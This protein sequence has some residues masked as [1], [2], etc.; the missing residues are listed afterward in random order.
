MFRLFAIL[1]IFVV[2]GIGIGETISRVRQVCESLE[3]DS[4]LA[5]PR[6]IFWLDESTVIQWAPSGTVQCQDV[7]SGKILWKRQSFFNVTDWSLSRAS[8]R[9]AIRHQGEKPDES[10][11]DS[12]ICVLDC[13]SGKTIFAKSESSPFGNENGEGIADLLDLDF[14]YVGCLAL[15][16]KLGKLVLCVS[17]NTY[18]KHGYILSRDFR[19]IEDR[20]SVDAGAESL[21]ISP[22]GHRSTIVGHDQVLC[23]HDLE[24]DKELLLRGDRQLV[25]PEKSVYV[26][27]PPY[28]SRASHDGKSCLVSR[29]NGGCW[30]EGWIVV[31][32]ISANTK[33]EFSPDG[34]YFVMDVDFNNKR[35]AVTG[36]SRDLTII[37]FDCNVV[38]KL[39][40]ATSKKVLCV[41]L[42]PSGDQVVT[43]SSDNKVTVFSITE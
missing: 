19:K 20:F 11:G 39:D 1:L 30:S 23:I 41:K 38:A 43:V 14:A 22:Q 12:T 2:P 35:I 9:L 15:T 27:G 40:H 37:D 7:Q 28:L 4:K 34:N 33:S 42:S 5:G 17:E 29:F 24:Q 21:S 6:H 3:D 26:T 10:F 16:P 32:D 8:S 31:E 25:P 36:D 13:K 18:G